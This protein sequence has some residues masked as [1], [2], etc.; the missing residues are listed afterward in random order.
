M[1]HS[2]NMGD[3]KV[4]L[5]HRGFKDRARRMPFHFTKGVGENVAMSHGSGDPG[6]EAVDGWIGS[7]GH[8]KNLLGEFKYMGI[9]VYTNREGEVYLTQMFALAD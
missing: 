4:K 8:R 9:G 5:S 3:K 7:P 2:K 1:G 6:K